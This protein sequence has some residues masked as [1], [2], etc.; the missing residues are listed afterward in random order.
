MRISRPNSSV[1][2]LDST[3]GAPATTSNGTPQVPVLSFKSPGTITRFLD[4]YRQLLATQRDGARQITHL[5][6]EIGEV[7]R[8]IGDREAE[9]TR[10]E[11]ELA[12]TR[13][14]AERAGQVL[15]VKTAERDGLVIA[16]KETSDQTEDLRHLLQLIAPDRLEE[17]EESQR[18]T[19]P[20]GQPAYPAT[21]NVPPAPAGDRPVAGADAPRTAPARA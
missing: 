19:P 1:G 18:Q 5:N 4:M 14:D 21:P 2:Q 3:N 8:H 16:H 10:L 12:R 20:Q 7:Q 15:Q 11:A 13:Q 9:I 6:E 17:V